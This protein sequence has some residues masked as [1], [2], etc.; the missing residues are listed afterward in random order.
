MEYWDKRFSDEGKIWGDKPSKSAYYATRVFKK[1][2]IKTILIPGSGYGR[3]SKLFSNAEFVVTGIEISKIALDLARN[4]DTKTRF[5]EGS[6]LNMPF[7]DEIYDVIYCF[8]V[9]HLFTKQDRFHFLKKCFNQLKFEGYIFFIV[10]SEKESSFGIGKQV[11]E[12]TFES[13]PGRPIHYFTRND[14]FEHFTDYITIKD[15]I[16]KEKENHGYIGKHIHV[17]RYIFAKKDYK[18]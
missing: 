10:F 11:E 15:G 4:F 7:S 9:L 2:D 5:Y 13:K 8:N 3:N 14:L 17:L 1:H 18:K 6:V 12:N 16:I